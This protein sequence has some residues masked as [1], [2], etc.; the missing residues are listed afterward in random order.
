MLIEILDAG[1]FISGVTKIFMKTE[2][3]EAVEIQDRIREKAGN[4]Q[5]SEQ[6]RKWRDMIS[7]MS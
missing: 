2:D 1:E 5:A 7:P 4:W 3:R 6:I